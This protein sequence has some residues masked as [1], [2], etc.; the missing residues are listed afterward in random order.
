MWLQ[1][2]ALIA[3]PLLLCGMVMIAAGFAMRHVRRGGTLL[4]LAMGV[5]ASFA[6][7]VFS[8]IVHALGLSARIPVELAAWAPAVVVLLIGLSMLVHLEDG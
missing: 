7:Y 6:L 8:D 3:E 2:H 5:G 4:I 1:M